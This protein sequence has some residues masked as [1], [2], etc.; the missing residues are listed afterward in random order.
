M[1][2][3]PKMAATDS[4]RAAAGGSVPSAPDLER[5]AAASSRRSYPFTPGSGAGPNSVAAMETGTMRAG[6]KRLAAVLALLCLTCF[7]TR[8]AMAQSMLR[9][10]ETEAWLTDISR[11]LFQAAGLSP[12]NAKVVLIQDPSINAFVA[13]GQIVYIH[14]GLLDAA[15]SA[16]QVQGVIAH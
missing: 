5:G 4:R 2:E 14:T 3:P 15:D 16:N 9:D 7:A 8:P 12:A 10:A 11:P 6:F 1:T 13:G